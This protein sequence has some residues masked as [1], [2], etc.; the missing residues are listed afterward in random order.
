MR[1]VDFLDNSSA[2]FCSEAFKAKFIDLDN[3]I[4]LSYPEMVN[5]SINL[6]AILAKKGVKPA[7]VVAT[8][9]PNSVAL[10]VAYLLF[11]ASAQF[12]YL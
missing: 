5:V 3:N 12:G 4:S 7:D 10:I 11:L 8:Y 9:S 1:L 2:L 6:A